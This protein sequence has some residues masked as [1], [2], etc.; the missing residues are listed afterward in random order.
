MSQRVF[1]FSLSKPLWGGGK[2]KPSVKSALQEKGKDPKP[3]EL[4]MA[5]VKSL[6]K[7]DGGPNPWV[8]QNPGM[9]C[10]K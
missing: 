8:V 1:L 4:A 10:G 3:G 9:S 7:S 6:D 2:G 5:R